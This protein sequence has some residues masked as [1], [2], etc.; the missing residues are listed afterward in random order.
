MDEKKI[1]A[2]I[3]LFGWSIVAFEAS[4]YLPSYAYTIGLGQ[5]YQHPEMIIFGLPVS[6]LHK[7]L[8]EAGAIVKSGKVLESHKVY[9]DFFENG[10]VQFVAVDK[11]SWNDYFGHGIALNGEHPF[12]A[13]QLV[14]TD[15]NY[16]FP[17]EDVFEEEFKFKQPLLDRNADFKFSEE[18]DLEVLAS[19]DHL[20]GK[21][22]ILKVV[23]HADG[24]W[25]FLTSNE[26]A[27]VP[28]ILGEIVAQDAT[29]ND[30]F[31]LDYGQC[32]ERKTRTDKWERRL[33]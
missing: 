5:K 28:A 21:V 30:L 15:R 6:I 10:H 11:R 27:T 17:W 3:E 29:L 14:W 20:E 9:D 24:E 26:E 25:L 23:H 22:S 1:N 32:A 4:D 16:K 33:A 12:S 8:N 13:L 31:D 2:D 18:K 19:I 7:V